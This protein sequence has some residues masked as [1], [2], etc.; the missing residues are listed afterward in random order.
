MQ[1]LSG[2]AVQIPPGEPLY[3]HQEKCPTEAINMPASMKPLPSAVQTA[4]SSST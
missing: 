3:Y 2:L 4:R 1:L